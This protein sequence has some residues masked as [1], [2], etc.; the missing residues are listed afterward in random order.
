MEFVPLAKA[1]LS[2]KSVPTTAEPDR[3]RFTVKFVEVSPVRARM[4]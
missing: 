3:F 4:K 1:G 2:V